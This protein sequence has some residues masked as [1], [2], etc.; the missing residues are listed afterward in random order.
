MTTIPTIDLLS[1]IEQR[2]P[3]R[4][5][6]VASTDGGEYAGNCPWCGGSDRFHVWPHSLKSKPHYWCRGCGKQGDAISFLMEWEHLDFR[7]ACQE[8]D[9][10]MDDLS[11]KGTD[12]PL[13]SMNPFPCKEWQQSALEFIHAAEKYLWSK[14]GAWARGYLLAR[15]ITDE[16]MQAK[17][18]GCIPL[19][20]GRWI[21][22]PF[23][24]WGLTPEMLTPDQWA[25]GC[26]RVPDGLLFPY[27][28]ED[29]KPWK[30]SMYRPLAQLLPDMKRGLIM[31]SKECLLNEQ[32]FTQDKP[33]IM[34][35]S[36]LDAISIEQEAGDLVIATS[37]DGTNSSRSLRCQAKLQYA[38]FVLQSFDGDDP[39]HAGA[40]WWGSTIKNCVRWP[41]LFGKD[42]NEMLA[43][44][45]P[46]TVRSWVQMGIERL[47]RYLKEPEQPAPVIE[48]T[49]EEAPIDVCFLCHDELHSYTDRGTPCCEKHY[50][51]RQAVELALAAHVEQTIQQVSSVDPL[52]QF[53]ITV[54]QIAGILAP[55][56]SCEIHRDLP[57]YTLQ[58]HVAFLN[59]KKRR[60]EIAR[61]IAQRRLQTDRRFKRLHPETEDV[62]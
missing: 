43:G 20:D 21:E 12:S 49:I 5:K 16:M 47:T 55:D 45:G 46:E 1:L 28:G 29:G 31:G 8:L 19:R 18:I 7:A 33:I 60:A 54:N 6:R 3:T 62:V 30:L 52:T 40:A 27:Y 25:K 50:E 22:T 41:A 44:Q 35:E 37:T 36:F 42:P 26:V 56:T 13:L 34:T 38:P 51:A 39:G 4:L 32:M 53:A 2:S 59:D 23:E 48:S 14:G 57:G 10:D 15:G 24:R 11:Y 58:D 9:I 61:E 17:H